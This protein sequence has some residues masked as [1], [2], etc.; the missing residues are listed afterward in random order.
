MKKPGLYLCIAAALSVLPAQ[1]AEQPGQMIVLSDFPRCME[2]R[3]GPVSAR[4]GERDP[5]TH[6]GMVPVGVSYQRVFNR[7]REAAEQKGGNAVVLR[8]HRADYFSKSARRPT[9]PTYIELLGTAVV[10]KEERDDCRLAVIDTV[11]FEQDARRRQ[12]EQHNDSTVPRSSHR[13][14]LPVQQGRQQP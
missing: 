13:S 10:L 3:L 4:L 1:A 6:T 7:L 12:R 5:N 14:L 9:R 2:S 11:Q 8:S